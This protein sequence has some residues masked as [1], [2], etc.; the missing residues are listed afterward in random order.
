M[1]SLLRLCLCVG[2]FALV[3]LGADQA[4]DTPPAP[5]PE[6]EHNAE[7]PHTEEGEGQDTDHLGDDNGETKE[8]EEVEEAETKIAL[9]AEAEQMTGLFEKIDTD[10]DGKMSMPEIIA[11]WK[12]TRKGMLHQSNAQDME[13][14]DTNKDKKVSLEEFIKKEESEFLDV[15]QG[16]DDAR[17]KSFDELQGAK[18]K[19]ADKNADGFLDEHE[20][21]DAVYGETHDEIVRIMA[22]HDLKMKDKDGDGKLDAKEFNELGEDPKEGDEIKATEGAEAGKVEAKDAKV[23][24]EEAESEKET[25]EEFKQQDT[26][27]D[28]KLNLEE[29][30]HWESGVFHI[31]L[32]MKKLFEVADQDKDS[33]IT[34][35][36]LTDNLHELDGSAANDHLNEWA[37]HHDSMLAHHGEL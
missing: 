16:A 26:D 33:H 11:F 20:L 18:F 22:A 19:T 32:D 23:A 4:E 21:P 7:E 24:E 17:K 36:E 15:E 3:A 2:V 12:I 31:T 27:G 34:L 25:A 10:K 9:P 28:G 13:L 29:L 5:A 8:E 37:E 35:K 30:V 6:G 1:S 14:M